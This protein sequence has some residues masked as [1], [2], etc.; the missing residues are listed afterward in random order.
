MP[1]FSF[2]S[3]TGTTEVIT[4]RLGSNTVANNGGLTDTEKGKFV[5]LAGSSRYD[6]AAAGNEIEGWVSSVEVATLDGYTIGGVA[7]ESE[8]LEVTFDGAQATP[9]TGTLA[10]GDYV[11]VGTVVAKGTALAADY[12]RRVCKATDQTAAKNSPFAWRVADL[13]TAGTGAVGTRG[14]IQRVS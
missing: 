11:V 12:S 10:I 7:T 2:Q 5:K 1:K 14:V 8:F 6:L 9:G 13:G 3:T 4:A